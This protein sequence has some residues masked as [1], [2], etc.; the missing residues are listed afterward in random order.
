MKRIG[1]ITIEKNVAGIE[2]LTLFHP[3]LHPDN[4]GCFFEAYNERELDELGFHV[5]FVQDNQSIS[6]KGVL[7]GLHYQ[8]EHPQGK[9]VRAVTGSFYDVAVDLRKNSPTFGKHYGIILSADNHM[10]MYIPEGFAH[11]FLVLE[12]GTV[13]FAKVTDYVQPGDGAGI[14]WN[15]PK[16]GIE[17]PLELIDGEL[18]MTEKDKS[19][20]GVNDL[21]KTQMLLHNEIDELVEKIHSVW[22]RC[23]FDNVISA[24]LSKASNEA[25]AY[26]KSFGEMWNTKI[27]EDGMI[28]ESYAQD[29]KLFAKIIKAF[30]MT[31]GFCG[32]ELETAMREFIA[33][34][35]EEHDNDFEKSKIHGKVI[36]YTMAIQHCCN[37]LTEE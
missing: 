8:K 1:Q 34:S 4:R 29:G 9:L 24:L 37:Q 31:D 21:M 13:F 16:L 33:V 5:R 3:T 25:K 36:E 7:R 23:D 32:S 18:I 30:E 20:P 12:E 6:H 19:Y 22:K 27:R 17:W 35:E 10:Q 11:G 2:G 15:D 14:R 28:R 26:I